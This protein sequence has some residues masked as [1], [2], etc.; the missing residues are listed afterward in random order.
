VGFTDGAS[1]CTSGVHL[2]AGGSGKPANVLFGG[3]NAGGGTGRPAAFGAA[4]FGI[5]GALGIAAGAGAAGPAG[6]R[7]DQPCSKNADFTLGKGGNPELR[8]AASSGS[9][10][11]SPIRVISSS[12]ERAGGGGTEERRLDGGGGGRE[13]E[14]TEHCA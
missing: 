11:I 3:G 5:G 6:G 9:A 4:A 2:T 14:V 7:D 12:C 8:C 1:L 10:S 13:A